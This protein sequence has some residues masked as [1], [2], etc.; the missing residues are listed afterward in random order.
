MTRL[1]L[2]LLLHL[3]LGFAGLVGLLAFGRLGTCWE[4]GSAAARS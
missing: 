4:E 3:K 1:L 2:V